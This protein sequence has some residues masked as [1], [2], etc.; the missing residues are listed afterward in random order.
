LNKGNFSY[1]DTQLSRL[2][3]NWQELPINR[4]VCPVLNNNRDG[5]GRHTITRGTINYWPNRLGAQP[6]AK[7]E[8]GGYF[9]YPEKIAGIKTRMRSKKFRDHFSQAQLF[10]NSMTPIERLHITN[11]LSFELDHCDDPIVYE[12][13]CQRLGEI[14][15][16]L[17]QQVAEMVGAPIP[18]ETT[19]P[20]HGKKAKGLSQFDFLPE[21]PTIATRRIAILLADG[22][23]VVS[24]GAV[25]A[26]ISAAQAIPFVIAPKRGPIYAA[27]EDKKSSK[28]LVPD[29]HLEGMRSTMFDSLYIPG[30][31]ESVATLRK[32]GR[33]LHWVREAFGHLKAIGA[34]GE[35]VALVSDACGGLPSLSLSQS[36]DVVESYGVVTA[37]KVQPESLKETVQI[38]KGAKE[39]LGVYFYAISLHRNFD[40]ELD[41]LSAMVAY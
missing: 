38:I 33:A 35:G 29:H 16:G 6:P 30:G 9:E 25:R 41:G 1:F 8:E 2:G 40:R 37:S 20:N 32:N 5:Q 34:T 13:M 12:R 4:P 23:D 17:A 36:T 15:L 19:R 10:F 14:D 26:A 3:I 24:Y 28:G 7:L 31:A 22:Y 27:G 18:K 11:A 21:K 39:F